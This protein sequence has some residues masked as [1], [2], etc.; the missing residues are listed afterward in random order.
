MFYSAPL[1]KVALHAFT[2]TQ[3]QSAF[4]L[5]WLALQRSCETWGSRTGVYW[6]RCLGCGL[7]HGGWGSRVGSRCY[8]HCFGQVNRHA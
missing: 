3:T 8:G 5:A 7:H 1:C 2:P 6:V 4:G